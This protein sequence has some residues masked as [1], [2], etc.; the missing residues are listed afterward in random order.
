MLVEEAGA[1]SGNQIIRIE[2]VNGWGD[3]FA[4]EITNDLAI[5]KLKIMALAH[6]HKDPLM[7]IKMA[8]QYKLV[9]MNKKKSLTEEATVRDEDLSENDVLL[10]LPRNTKSEEFSSTSELKSQAPGETEIS[11]A[12]SH[13][14]PRNSSRN[15]VEFPSN[16]DV[17]N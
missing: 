17:S 6:F 3:I 7:S 14:I 15:V 16:I 4:L 2:V 5:E 8:Q 9:S 11:E 10:L 13:L 1:F 12:T